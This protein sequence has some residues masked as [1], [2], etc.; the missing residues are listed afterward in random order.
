MRKLVPLLLLAATAAPA[1]ERVDPRKGPP[2]GPGWADPSDVLAAEIAFSRLA[3]DKGQW[4]AF[5][6]TA[7]PNAQQFNN[8]PVRVADDLKGRKDPPVA[9]KW[10]PHAVWM[11][12][13]GSYAVT[14][15]AWQ[16]PKATGWFITVWQ[17]Q[18]KGGYK[19]VLDQGDALQT[20]LAAPEFLTAKV[21]ECP[22]RKRPDGN[23]GHAPNPPAPDRN[24]PPP[25]YT[26]AHSD[27]GTLTWATTATATGHHFAVTLR[28]DG[29]PHEV[30]AADVA[31]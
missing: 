3:Q 15:G 28:Q 10:Q 11:A 21:A 24:A 31:N 4:T 23:P 13:D 14:R 5:R 29:V 2:H 7:A 6:A 9:V 8:G 12:C 20:P 27:D 1:Q 16:G 26:S 30:L 19:W 18:K 22:P 17:R 25:D